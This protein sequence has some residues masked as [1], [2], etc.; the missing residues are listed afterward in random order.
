VLTHAIPLESRVRLPAARFKA[1][2]RRVF[3]ALLVRLKLGLAAR[4][5]RAQVAPVLQVLPARAAGIKIM[6]HIDRG[7]DKGGYTG[8]ALN[9][10]TS[11]ITNAQQQGVVFDVFGESC[12]QAYQGDP[13]SA[14]N[15]K[16][17]WANTFGGLATKF[18]TLQFVAAEYG[19]LQR[20]INDVVFNLPGNRGLGTFNWEPTQNGDWNT[21]HTLFDTM[22]NAHTAGPDLGLYD[23]MKTVYAGRL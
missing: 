4:S 14:A 20:E 19:P 15:T 6:L 5:S 3:W 11:F 23:T 10:S 1:L 8:A 18:P 22:G 12:Y 17:D 7:G 21:G 13:A 16:T 9:T 2:A